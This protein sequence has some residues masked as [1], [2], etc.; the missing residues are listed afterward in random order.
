MTR[1]ART[2][3][4]QT[5]PH[6]TPTGAAM[7]RLQRLT[8]ARPGEICS[9]TTGG[10]DRSGGD[11]WAMSLSEH[12]DAHRGRGRTNH[13]NATAQAVPLPF[14]D[15][16]VPT[17]PIFSPAAADAAH[18]EARRA[19]RVTPESRGNGPGTNCVRRHKRRPGTR[20]NVAAY[21]RALTRACDA[22]FQPPAPLPQR[23]GETRAAP[24]WPG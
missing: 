8:G 15:L 16:A 24:I 19:A 17:A 10:I 1:F 6:L 18:R 2:A 11:L 22:A 20:Y 14:L 9:L 23:D 13:A 5:L 4:E 3:V 12:K 21:R 7:V